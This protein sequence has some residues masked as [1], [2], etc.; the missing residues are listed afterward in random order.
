METELSG[1]HGR[2]ADGLQD[3]PV[4]GT[5]CHFWTSPPGGQTGPPVRWLGQSDGVR[6]ELAAPGG[7]PRG[8]SIPLMRRLDELNA[9]G[10]DVAP[11]ALA[12]SAGWLLPPDLAAT[13]TAPQQTLLRQFAFADAAAQI[14]QAR[15]RQALISLSVVAPTAVAALEV[16]KDG[17]GPQLWVGVLAIYP[18]GL[19]W[20]VVR[21]RGVRARGDDTRQIDYRALAEGLRIQLVWSLAGI[22][23]DVTDEYLHTLRGEFQWVRGAIRAVVLAARLQAP[24]LVATPRL[25]VVQAR[26]VADQRAYFQRS[27]VDKQRRARRFDR[28]VGAFLAVSF[29]ASVALGPTRVWAAVTSAGAGWDG[30]LELFGALALACA[31]ALAAVVERL[32]LPEL[33]RQHDRMFLVFR[34]AEA[35]LEPMIAEADPASAQA[36]VAELGR[37]A[38]HEN[39]AWVLLHRSRPMEAMGV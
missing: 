27:V 5:V 21:V 30:S 19:L 25:D 18:L 36:V 39:A 13:T 12:Q 11:E 26:W 20:G 35:W 37:V 10:A 7:L 4:G 1:R 24:D 15:R 23:Q 29:V 34:R 28:V 31:A 3:D 16:Y 6:H 33:A 2:Q 17:L 22:D 8:G 14:Y 38:L 9:V 32:H